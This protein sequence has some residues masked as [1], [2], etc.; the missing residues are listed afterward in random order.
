MEGIV[1]GLTVAAE[2]EVEGKE[3]AMNESKEKV[4]KLDR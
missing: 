2:G 3:E 1:R 4:R